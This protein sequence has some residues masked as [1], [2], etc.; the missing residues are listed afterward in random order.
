VSLVLGLLVLV[1]RLLGAFAADL[2]RDTLLL[3]ALASAAI[4]S[5]TR[6]LWRKHFPLKSAGRLTAGDLLVGWGSS[7]ALLMLAIGCCYPANHTSDWLI[8]LPVLVADQFWRQSF[9][10]AGHPEQAVAL[11]VV[12]PDQPAEPLTE[13]DND[14]DDVVQQLFRVRS[15]SGSEEIYGTLRADFHRG[16]RTAVLHVGFCPPL[17]H[18]PEVEAEALGDPGYATVKTVQA[19][20][21]GA[22][23]D[24]RL[25]APAEDDC[26]VWIDMAARPVAHQSFA[27][28][29]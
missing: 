7:A 11:R 5:A 10:D 3:T 28:G 22:R 25:A 20:A 17:T 13:A 12:H 26:R 16:Q 29:A 21:H 24:V 15:E 18:R 14:A 4:L 19:L 1:R 9:F 6:L 8:W 27:A 2:P 23:L